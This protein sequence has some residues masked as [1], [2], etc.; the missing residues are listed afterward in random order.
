MVFRSPIFAN[1][2][3]G[4]GVQ[5]DSVP[6]IRRCFSHSAQCIV[7]SLAFVYVVFLAAFVLQS[8]YRKTYPPLTCRSWGGSR[9]RQDHNK[10]GKQRPV[11]SKEFSK[12][13]DDF[14]CGCFDLISFLCKLLIWV[15]KSCRD[16]VWSYFQVGKLTHPKASRNDDYVYAPTPEVQ[17]GDNPPR[18]QSKAY[19]TPKS[20]AYV[21]NGRSST[22]ESG[23]A[24]ESR[25]YIL[26]EGYQPTAGSAGNVNTLTKHAHKPIFA[27]QEMLEDNAISTIGSSSYVTGSRD[28]SQSTYRSKI[29]G[30][31]N[32][33]LIPKHVDFFG[34]ESEPDKKLEQQTVESS[35]AYVT[36]TSSFVAGNT[37]SSLSCITD[38]NNFGADKLMYKAEQAHHK[39]LNGFNGYHKVDS[40]LRKDNMPTVSDVQPVK[41]EKPGYNKP[42]YAVL[43]GNSVKVYS[44]SMFASLPNHSTFMVKERQKDSSGVARVKLALKSSVDQRYNNY[45]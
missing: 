4:W 14:Q 16:D 7:L 33:T 32:S 25:N 35:G 31:G 34:I 45:S 11:R 19:V 23:Y 37:G 13:L 43:V 36:R 28:Y 6:I 9:I 20:F 27:K 39:H 2:N 3:D 10:S 24:T 41:Q 12:Q 18:R 8:R 30:A 22:R 44:T 40:W 17:R 15:W 26:A 1:F 42:T 21:D 29:V 5:M 38:S